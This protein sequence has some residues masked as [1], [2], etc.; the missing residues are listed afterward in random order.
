MYSKEHTHHH[1]HACGCDHEHHSE[2]AC[3]CGHEH[4]SE[5]ACGCGHEH[6]HLSTKSLILRLV[7]GALL[8]AAAIAHEHFGSVYRLTVVLFAAAY[9]VLGYDIIFTAI[10]NIFKGRVF[11]ENFLMTVAGVGAFIIGE[12]PEAVAVM[13]FY[14]IGEALQD[15]AVEQSKKSITELMD[16]RPD[17]ANIETDG[18]ITRVSP[19]DVSVGDVILVKPGERV[20][21]DGIIE[22]GETFIDTSALTG[23]SVPRHAAAGDR[24]LSGSVNTGSPVYVKVE[25][26]YSQSTVSKILDMAE[27]AQSKKARSEKFITNFAKIYTPIVVISAVLLAIVPPIFV[28]EFTKWLYRGLIFLV[29]S[30]PCALV[31]S[32]PLGFFAGIGCASKNGILIKGSDYLERLSSLDTVV[33]DKTGTLTEGVFTVNKVHALGNKDAFLETAAYAEFYSN[34]PIAVSIKNAFGSDAD[35]DRISDYTEIPGKGISVKIDGKETLAGSKKLMSDNSIRFTEASEHGSI[36]YIASEGKFMGYIAISDKIKPDS[37]AAVNSLKKLGISTVMLTGDSEKQADYTAVEIGIDT[38]YSQLL[39]QDKVNKFETILASK[40]KNKSVAFI[41][42][43]INDAPV[44][45]RADVG[46]AMG[47]I[48]SDSAIEAADVVL[49]TDEPTKLITGIKISQKTMKIVREN[50]VF[51]IGVKLLVMLLSAVGLSSMWP[52]I[53]ADVGVTMIA[54]LNSLRALR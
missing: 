38:V 53:F 25:H 15:K 49:M 21:L 11:D 24:V 19:A 22:N 45:S 7:I 12:H 27:N 54:V 37:K 2:H 9:A 28:G 13:L 39:P 14:Q 51:A 32:I 10:K 43:G 31:V 4:H 41:G 46:I 1:E 20:P 33:F 3:G 6:N 17:Y 18:K 34:H 48:G 47:G 40:H 5:H 52:A 16:I 30:C 23:E 29:V 26:E 8:F 44:L 35:T 36:V 42:D 50:I